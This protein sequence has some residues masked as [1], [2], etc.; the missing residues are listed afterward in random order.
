MQSNK[1]LLGITLPY[2]ISVN[3]VLVIFPEVKQK[4][5]SG[6]IQ[7]DRDPN[8]LC[9]SRLILLVDNFICDTIPLSPIH[10]QRSKR[11]VTMIG[12]TDVNNTTFSPK[13]SRKRR[14][15]AFSGAYE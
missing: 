2:Q 12:G 5:L 10:G 15:Y 7:H 13:A 1:F 8:V 3:V 9:Q 4:P 6:V 11:S 14:V